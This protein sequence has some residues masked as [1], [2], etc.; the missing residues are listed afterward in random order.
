MHGHRHDPDTR[1]KAA[2]AVVGC[3]GVDQGP[4]YVDAG[5]GA[6][7]HRRHER[8]FQLVGRRGLAGLEREQLLC[9]ARRD[10]D[11]GPDVLHGADGRDGAT[12]QGVHHHDRQHHEARR[13]HADR[14]RGGFE[15]RDGGRDRD[16]ARHDVGDRR[17]RRAWQARDHRGARR[18]S[19]DDGLEGLVHDAR[20]AGAG[21][22]QDGVPGGEERGVSAQ[23]GRHHEERR[24]RPHSQLHALAGG[25]QLRAVPV[26]PLR[27]RA[28]RVQQRHLRD[29]TPP[30]AV[31]QVLLLDRGVDGH[32]GLEA[33]CRRG[34][35]GVGAAR[36]ARNALR[37][38][39]SVQPDAADQGLDGRAG[40]RGGGAQ[41]G[42]H[43]PRGRAPDD[44]AEE[45]LRDVRGVR[46][47]PRQALLRQHR[48]HQ[49]VRRDQHAR[50]PR[51]ARRPPALGL[52]LGHRRQLVLLAQGQR[53]L[54]PRRDPAAAVLLAD[55]G[56]GAQLRERRR[57]LWA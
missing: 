39:R 1:S 33:V 52:V 9:G 24:A 55:A 26:L 7:C 36:G 35:P 2:E 20:D 40:A 43:V 5:V 10:H 30:A 28:G 25:L 46:R 21:E 8:V 54:H 50:A 16:R 23:A 51:E 29:L 45:H 6:I 12:P 14:G 32:G 4:C 37:D 38:P 27:R 17:A 47:D 22:P 11:A 42:A 34:V 49:R 3:C 48:R 56:G 57:D 41:A 53:H 31:A 19:A 15:Q 18:D 13:A 44:V